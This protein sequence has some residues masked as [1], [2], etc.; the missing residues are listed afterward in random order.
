MYALVFISISG[1]LVLVNIDFALI[2]FCIFAILTIMAEFSYGHREIRPYSIDIHTWAKYYDFLREEPVLK[3]LETQYNNIA[4]QLHE[5]DYELLTKTTYSRPVYL[6]NSLLNKYGILSK[7]RKLKAEKERIKNEYLMME[8]LL[9][10]PSKIPIDTTNKN[11]PIG[12][13]GLFVII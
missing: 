13:P 7:H 3:D 8:K 5:I 10:D 12:S 4:I 1:L 6:F 9:Y 11:A 2:F